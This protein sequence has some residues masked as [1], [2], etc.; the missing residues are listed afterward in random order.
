MVGGDNHR[1]GGGEVFESGHAG[2]E[3]G[4]QDSGDC[5]LG[6]FVE[7]HVNSPEV[8]IDCGLWRRSAVDA[9]R[10][11]PSEYTPPKSTKSVLR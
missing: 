5:F 3:D 6:G 1:A 7:K 8:P 9:G 4:A 2:A 10:V 11:A